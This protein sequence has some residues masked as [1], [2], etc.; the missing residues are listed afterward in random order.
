MVVQPGL[1]QTWSETPKTGFLITRLILPQTVQSHPP[2]HL[3][4]AVKM[5]AVIAGYL[6]SETQFTVKFLIYG[7][8]KLCCNHGNSPKIQTKRPNLKVFC[9]KHANGI[10]NSEDPDQTSLLGAV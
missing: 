8:K 2:H 9:Q 10:A 4:W 1:C 3:E 6:V 5:S 7:H